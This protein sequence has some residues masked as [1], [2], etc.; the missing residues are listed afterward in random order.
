MT[1]L[2]RNSMP[3]PVRLDGRPAA[4]GS[5]TTE[6]RIS[7]DRRPPRLDPH[8]GVWP[9]YLPPPSPQDAQHA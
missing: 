3:W 4:R 8:G 9:R 7:V 5:L 2:A 6:S 1:R